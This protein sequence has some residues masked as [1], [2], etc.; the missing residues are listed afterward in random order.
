MAP[1][2]CSA[3]SVLGERRGVGKSRHAPWVEETRL[4][5]T[6]SVSE[7][8]R[9]EGKAFGVLGHAVATAHIL[10]YDERGREAVL[11]SGSFALTTP[12]P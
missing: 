6:Q 10:Q 2:L 5:T 3:V 1:G 8:C 4:R 12:P 9:G 7:A 11:P